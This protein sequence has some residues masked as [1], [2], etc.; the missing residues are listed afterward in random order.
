MSKENQNANV[1]DKEKV[2]GEEAGEKGRN[3]NGDATNCYW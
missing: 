2:K 1:E 3:A